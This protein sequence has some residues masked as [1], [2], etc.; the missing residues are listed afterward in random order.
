MPEVV[1]VLCQSPSIE[2]RHTN[3]CY[4]ERNNHVSSSV[5]FLANHCLS[6]NAVVEKS[7]HMDLNAVKPAQEIQGNSVEQTTN[8]VGEAVLKNTIHV[9]IQCQWECVSI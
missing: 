1:H 8:T 2:Y 9:N 7:S 3:N 4:V 6:R 5:T